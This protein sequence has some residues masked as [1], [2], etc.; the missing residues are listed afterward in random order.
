MFIKFKL[1][2]V[3]GVWN[4][5]ITVSAVRFLWPPRRTIRREAIIFFLWRFI[6]NLFIFVYPSK[7]LSLRDTNDEDGSFFRILEEGKLKSS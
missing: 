6:L 1:L 2:T 5:Q 4:R 3:G 7:A